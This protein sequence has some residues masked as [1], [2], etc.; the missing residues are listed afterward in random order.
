MDADPGHRHPNYV[1]L[2]LVGYGL[3][4]FEG[5]LIT[6]LGFG[7]K[8]DLF[9]DLV[10]RGVARTRGT[11]KNRQDLF[12]PLVRGGKVGWWQNGDRYRHRKTQLDILFGGLDAIQYADMLSQFLD[13]EFPEPGTPKRTLPPL[14]K[15][16]FQQLQKTGIEAELYFLQN[17]RM[18][19]TFADAGIEDARQLGDGYDFQLTLG[20][21]YW[22][23]EIKGTRAR[24]GAVRL[25][26]NEFDR[27]QELRDRFCLVVV[28]NLDKLPTMVPIFDPLRQINLT[29]QIIV[30]E[31]I[32]YHSATLDW[33]ERVH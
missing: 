21:E 25:T 12:N 9:R 23:A 5:R 13:A 4:K 18:V 17:Y 30:S 3:A 14:M 11:L 29:R 31:Q 7:S 27:A 26:S 1:A 16:Q 19:A 28:A 33:P 32:Y 10:V 2:N 15:S 6:A 22:V 24:T 8:A 20:S